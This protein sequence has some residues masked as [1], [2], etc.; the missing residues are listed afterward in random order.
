[1]DSAKSL[2][3]RK[4][5][6]QTELDSQFAILKANNSTLQTPLVDSQ[7]FPRADIDVYAVRH[8]RVRI[9][10]LRNDLRA[11]IDELAVALEKV[12]DP[13][14]GVLGSQRETIRVDVED[15]VLPSSPF[16][17]VDGVAP[18]SPAAQ[19]VYTVFLHLFLIIYPIYNSG[20]KA[21]R[22]YS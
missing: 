21:W 17:K 19:A 5:S 4:E 22:S 14:N 2:I 13:A 11:V 20:I 10:E 7:G 3:S 6:L 16:A 8:A 15:N 18:A 1:M 12:Y 9:I